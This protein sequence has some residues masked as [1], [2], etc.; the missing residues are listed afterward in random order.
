MPCREDAL[1]AMVALFNVQRVISEAI[2]RDLRSKTGLSLAQ[3]E[4]L[5][6]LAD[7]PG[8]KLRMVDISER[9]CVSKSG[10]TQLV[11][12]LE[13]VGLVAR[14]SSR[15]DRRLTYAKITREG[16]ETLRRSQPKLGSAVQ[17]NFA[18]YLSDPEMGWLHE[19]L[20]KVLE[21]HGVPSEA[22]D[23]PARKSP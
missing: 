14:E 7:A 12:R 18:R 21:G 16:R 4:V 8:G 9:I 5:L 11:D 22:T 19:A 3:Y 23:A 1:A 13:E 17:E 6:R 15:S 2:E 10:V 20:R